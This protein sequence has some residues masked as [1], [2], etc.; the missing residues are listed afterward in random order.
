MNDRETAL[1]ALQISAQKLKALKSFNEIK[2]YYALIAV[3]SIFPALYGLVIFFG[4]RLAWSNK[5]LKRFVIIPNFLSIIFFL[6]GIFVTLNLINVFIGPAAAI[7]STCTIW[8]LSLMLSCFV[9]G[10]CF[11]FAL[12]LR[13]NRMNKIAFEIEALLAI[14]ESKTD[15]R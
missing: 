12:R 6:M 7:N 1:A 4:L 2:S 8:L 10:L 5:G 15:A 13:K 14:V 9:F 3:C 11:L